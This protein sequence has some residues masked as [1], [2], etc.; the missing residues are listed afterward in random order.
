MFVPGPDGPSVEAERWLSLV[1]SGRL[2]PF[3]PVALQDLGASKVDLICMPV[4][5]MYPMQYF[6]SHAVGEAAA[7][8]PEL[9]LDGPPRPFEKFFLDNIDRF[10]AIP[11][12]LDMTVFSRAS[13]S[14]KGFG[15]KK[16]CNTHHSQRACLQHAIGY[17]MRGNLR[18]S[19]ITALLSAGADPNLPDAFGVVPLMLAALAP[20]AKAL[21]IWE[22]LRAFGADPS[23][24]SVVQSSYMGGLAAVSARACVSGEPISCTSMEFAENAAPSFFSALEATREAADLSSTARRN[25]FPQRNLRRI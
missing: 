4:N 23:R 15:N 11:G 3:A 13:F 5:V 24:E 6:F 19:V 7:V 9:L 17:D 22:M 1:E 21:R 16:F 10:S 12:L 8:E 25:S 18:M 20:P 14:I 2:D